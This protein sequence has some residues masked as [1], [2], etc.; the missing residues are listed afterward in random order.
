MLKVGLTGG[1]GSGKSTVA[2]V[3]QVLGIPVFDSDAAGKRLLE[4]SGPEREAVIAAFGA[5]LYASGR[6]DRS[7]LGARVFN[8][9]EALARLNSIVHP[10]VRKRFHEWATQQDAPYIMMEAAILAQTGGHALFDRIVLVNAPADLRLQRVMKRDGVNA[11]TVQARMDRQGSDAD[12]ARIAH[13]T[14]HNDEQQLVIPQVLQVHTA[15]TTLA[16][17]GKP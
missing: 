8:D 15:L 17:D 11:A 2:R 1:I 9:P 3:F 16:I 7:V 4:E 12:R 5:H 10:A 14:I 6:L 13:F